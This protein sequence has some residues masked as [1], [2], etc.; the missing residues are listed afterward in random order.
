MSCAFIEGIGTE[1]FWKDRREK[2]IMTYSCSLLGLL[3]FQLASVRG[4]R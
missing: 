4:A 2:C 3:H 1:K